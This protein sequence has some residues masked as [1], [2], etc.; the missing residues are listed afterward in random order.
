MLLSHITRE[1][2]VEEE[3]GGTGKIPIKRGC[4]V[5]AGLL[6]RGRVLVGARV[7]VIGVLCRETRFKMPLTLGD[8]WT[9]CKGTNIPK[10]AK[11]YLSPK[12][13]CPVPLPSIRTLDK[14]FVHYNRDRFHR[15]LDDHQRAPYT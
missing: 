15:S 10:S 13:P 3:G 5:V 14:D 8:T 2:P 6:R 12:L 1:E 9:F 11:R 4:P 7:V